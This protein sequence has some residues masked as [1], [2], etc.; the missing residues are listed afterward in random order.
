MILFVF[1][2]IIIREIDTITLLSLIKCRVAHP[3]CRR[4][5]RTASFVHRGR[6]LVPRMGK[7]RAE[8]APGRRGFD[9]RR[10]PSLARREKGKLVF[11][12]RR[13]A[14]REKH[15]NRMAGR[16]HGRGIRRTRQINTSACA[17][18][19]AQALVPLAVQEERVRALAFFAQMWYNPK[20]KDQKRGP[21]PFFVGMAALDVQ[22]PPH[23]LLCGA[24]LR[25]VGKRKGRKS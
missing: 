14:P 18:S 19:P 5:R 20:G 21:F 15:L 1:F 10:G 9:P 6:R 2:Y 24:R 16:G 3:P 13:R 17:E 25:A 7:T 4:G 11:A 22:I 8:L 23:R 12:H